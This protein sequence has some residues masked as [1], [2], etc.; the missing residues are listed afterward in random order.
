[1]KALF[2]REIKHIRKQNSGVW[3]GLLTETSC[4]APTGWDSQH[5]LQPRDT[6]LLKH[7]YATLS[8]AHDIQVRAC[9]SNS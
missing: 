3:Q 5:V 1:M 9:Y 8:R 7:L 6:G 2:S 4:I